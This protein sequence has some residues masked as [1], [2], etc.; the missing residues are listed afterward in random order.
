MAKFAISRQRMVGS[1]IRYATNIRRLEGYQ[2]V[3]SQPVEMTFLR[4]FFDF[5]VENG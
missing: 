4:R 3:K 5:L 2:M 1:P